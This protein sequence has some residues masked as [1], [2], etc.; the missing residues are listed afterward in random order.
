MGDKLVSQVCL[1]DILYYI[2]PGSQLLGM[3]KKKWCLIFYLFTVIEN[4]GMK[5]NVNEKEIHEHKILNAKM[6]VQRPPVS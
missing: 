3:Q 1:M 2:I 4:N 6:R 5:V